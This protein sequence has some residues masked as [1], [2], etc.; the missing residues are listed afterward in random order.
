[1][2]VRQT[3]AFDPLKDTCP[4]RWTLLVGETG[5]DRSIEDDQDRSQ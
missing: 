4:Q 3:G 2:I 5:I 1:M